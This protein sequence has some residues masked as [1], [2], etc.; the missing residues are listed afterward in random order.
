MVVSVVVVP[1]T[2]RPTPANVAATRNPHSASTGKL[3]SFAVRNLRSLIPTPSPVVDS[4]DFLPMGR[5]PTSLYSTLG[6]FDQQRVARAPH[7][8]RSNSPHRASANDDSAELQS[9]QQY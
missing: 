4:G 3:T 5:P 9:A 2:P 7:R 6:A 8:P 1:P